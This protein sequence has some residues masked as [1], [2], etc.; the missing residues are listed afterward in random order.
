ME[1]QADIFPAARQLTKR[2]LLK[3]AGGKGQLLDTLHRAMPKNFHR[4][5]SY[6]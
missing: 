1:A 6:L 4:L 2:P 3:W 5:R